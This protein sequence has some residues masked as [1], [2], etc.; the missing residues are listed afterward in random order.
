M[1]LAVVTIEIGTSG[2]EDSKMTA[3]VTYMQMIQSK[4][5]YIAQ[6]EDYTNYGE[7]LSTQN[8]STLQGILNSEKESFLKTITF[9][10]KKA[11]YFKDIYPI[12]ERIITNSE[13]DLTKYIKFSIENINDYLGINTVINYSSDI[14]KDKTLKAQSMIIEICKTLNA[15][16][17][18]NAI[19]G[20]ELYDKN[21]FEEEGI[22]L[23]FIK[24]GPLSYTQFNNS[25]VE[26]LSILDILMFNSKYDIME[27]LEKYELI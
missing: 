3:F 19:G 20:Q 2:I 13:E 24:T 5:D 22:Q 8:M 6:N 27:M 14:K 12:I 15:D 25:F 21:V 1:I 26:N 23:N 16:I 7:S 17:Y 10:Y 9:A 4:V 18:V 11:K